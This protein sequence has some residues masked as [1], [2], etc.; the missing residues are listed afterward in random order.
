MDNDGYF[1]DGDNFAKII[2]NNIYNQVSAIVEFVAN[3]YDEDATKVRIDFTIEEDDCGNVYIIEIA[4]T[5]DGNGFSFDELNGLREIGNSRKS[6]SRYTKKFKR[7]KLGSFG[8][9]LTAFQ[10]LGNVLEIYSKN[11]DSQI[12]YKRIQ[13]S[14]NMA[15]FSEIKKLDYCDIIGF[16]TGCKF[17]IKNCKILKSIFFNTDEN[18]QY[19]DLLRNKLSY[20]PIG[21]DFKIQLC[22]DEI[23][24]FVV[25]DNSFKLI[26][27][28]IIN[29]IKYNGE[30]CYSATKV[31]NIHYRGV[32]LQIDGRIIDWNIYND[33]RQGISSPGSVDY[34]ICGYITANGI[35]DKINAGRNGVTESYLSASI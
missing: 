14:D 4:I 34:R 31:D 10:N 3:F 26:F 16:E 30:V 7:A 11:N 20:L 2:S 18:A 33:I 29:D 12:L 28:F 25:A 8:I 17:V 15:I 27:E 22:D 19:Y 13:T 32:F 24:R 6:E 9:A 1:G 35:R 5:G 21:N 23:N